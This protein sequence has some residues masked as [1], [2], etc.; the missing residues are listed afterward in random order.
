MHGYAAGFAGLVRYID[1]LIPSNEVIGQALRQT[2]KLYP[3]LAVRELVANALLHQDFLVSG[4]GPTVEI[5]DDRMEITNPGRPLVD[6]LRFVD[7][8]PVSRNERMGRA[9]RRGG[10]CEERG[11]GW[12]KV[13]F[14]IEFHQL[15]APLVEVTQEHTRVTL[16]SHRDLRDMD[17]ADRV[18][19]VYLHACLRYVSA[20]RMTNTSVR[21]RFGIE[22][23][24]SARASRLIKEAI[25]G[26]LI[27]LR[28]P[29]APV[30]LREY[31]PWWAAPDG[32]LPA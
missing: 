12:D 4:S 11:S 27:G 2:V 3:E 5:F 30:K 28:D 14:E 16:Y 7:S 9:M 22:A 23:H 10:L 8:P 6:P 31:V 1:E 20:Q 19:A 21:A 18:R 25:D 26:E 32:S 17:R 13:A 29:Q 15:P 24:N